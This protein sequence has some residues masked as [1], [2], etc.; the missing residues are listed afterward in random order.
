M[1]LHLLR[2]AQPNNSSASGL[3]YDREL[4][5]EGYEQLEELIDTIK[6]S[7]AAGDE[8]ATRN[9]ENWKERLRLLRKRL[10]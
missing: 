8:E 6:Y 1:K 3:D 7:H 2:H 4:A 5:R 9:I 10:L